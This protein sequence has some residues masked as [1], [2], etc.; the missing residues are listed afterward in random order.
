MD[1]L[2]RMARL[3]SHG[4]ILGERPGLTLI[5]GRI[6]MV[7]EVVT[8]ETFLDPTDRVGRIT[9]LNSVGQNAHNGR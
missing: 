2:L 8:A 5:P 4:K 3:E 6:E 1:H 7:I 9:N